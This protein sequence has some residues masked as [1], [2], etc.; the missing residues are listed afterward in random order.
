MF[1]SLRINSQ[2]FILHKDNKPHIEVGSVVSVSQPVPKFIVPQNFGQPQEMV[3]DVVVSVNG[4]NITY[5]RLPANQDVA[6]FGNNGYVVVA[7]SRDAM[8]MEVTSLKQKSVDAINSTDY[9]RNVINECD[10]ILQQLNPEYAEKQKQQSEIDSLKTQMSNMS[11]EVSDLVA[12]NKEL[13]EKLKAD[14]KNN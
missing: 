13:L 2:F 1:Q 6:D 4:Q 11:K 8:N 5:S 9:H 7:A 3:V 14:S 12:L 10:V